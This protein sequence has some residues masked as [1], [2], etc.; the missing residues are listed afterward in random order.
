MH[1]LNSVNN[2][3]IILCKN[4]TSN[5]YNNYTDILLQNII[6]I[7]DEKPQYIKKNI[8]YYDNETMNNNRFY[9]MHSS[10]KITAWDKAFYYL[11]N[12]K[13]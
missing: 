11:K 8:F 10:I 5:L 12:N 1:K 9:G 6:F 2:Y 4:V 13:L 7:S 3:Y